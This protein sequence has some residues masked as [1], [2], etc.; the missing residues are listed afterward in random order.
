MLFW[1]FVITLVIGIVLIVGG[2]MASH[3]TAWFYSRNKIKHF[4][5]RNGDDG[6]KT[7][8][9]VIT[10]MSAIIIIFMLILILNNYAGPGSITDK[11][12]RYKIEKSYIVAEIND[13][14][15]YDEHGLLQKDTMYSIEYWNDFV[16]F[17]KKYQRNFWIGIFIPNIF[18]DIETIDYENAL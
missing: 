2:K 12:K 16:E 11:A 10:I 17:H 6:I 7:T 4:M 18:D 3:S 8:G 9:I 14:K 15:Y 1:L 5:N 13:E